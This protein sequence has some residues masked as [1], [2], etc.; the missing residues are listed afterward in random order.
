MDGQQQIISS[1]NALRYSSSR[2]AVRLLQSGMSVHVSIALILM[3]IS[4]ISSALFASWLC[5]NSQ[6]VMNSCG[7]GLYSILMLS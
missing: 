4:G 2:V 3:C 5:L 1:A 6:S 7:P